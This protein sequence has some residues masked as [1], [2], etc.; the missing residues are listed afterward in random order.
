M[1]SIS[2]RKIDFMQHGL[3]SRILWADAH[4]SKWRENARH[5]GPFPP[6]GSHDGNGLRANRNNLQD[7][8]P[9]AP[10]P[11]QHPPPSGDIGKSVTFGLRGAFLHEEL[12]NL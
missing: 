8:E 9:Q 10:E 5:G 2:I 3:A 7:E 12:G 4:G 11:V 1:Q 6:S